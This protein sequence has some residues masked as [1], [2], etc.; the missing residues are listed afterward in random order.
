M[1]MEAVVTVTNTIQVQIVVVVV[2]VLVDGMI[3]VPRR[4]FPGSKTGGRG[5]GL[6]HRRIHEQA[7]GIGI[8]A[9]SNGRNRGSR[10]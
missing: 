5:E 8:D 1:V 10:P 7:V 4:D 3:A 6:R 2:R 9:P